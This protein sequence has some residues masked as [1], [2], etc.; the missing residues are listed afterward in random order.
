MT[1]RIGHNRSAALSPSVNVSS[2]DNYFFAASG[3][4]IR[5][6]CGK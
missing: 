1:G 6:T 5:T 3:I 2:Q 4:G